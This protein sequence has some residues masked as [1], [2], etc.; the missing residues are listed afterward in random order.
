[1]L[2]K[3]LCCPTWFLACFVMPQLSQVIA[4]A[5]VHRPVLQQKDAVTSAASHIPHTLAL[6]ELAFPRLQHYLLINPT[7]TQLSVRGIPP[8]QHDDGPVRPLSSAGEDLQ[9]Q[10]LMTH[11]HTHTPVRGTLTL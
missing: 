6:K 4:A 3:C 7:Q 2:V 5:G 1:M 11:T 10:P 9:V 8:A